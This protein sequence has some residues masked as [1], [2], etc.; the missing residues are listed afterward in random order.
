MEQIFGN[1]S[2]VKIFYDDLRVHSETLQKH[3]QNLDSVFSQL[4]KYNLKLNRPKCEFCKN[5]IKLIGFVV[6]GTGITLEKSKIEDISE[7]AH[8]LGH[9]QTESTFK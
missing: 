9:F 3:L 2:F 7:K 5:S 6:S 1:S 4:K 8:L